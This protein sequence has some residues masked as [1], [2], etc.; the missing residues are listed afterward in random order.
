M[1][2]HRKEI[3]FFCLLFLI[4]SHLKYDPYFLL[5]WHFKNLFLF[6]PKNS[7]SPLYQIPVKN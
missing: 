1:F 2:L 3:R 7:R 4:E 6:V 5:L